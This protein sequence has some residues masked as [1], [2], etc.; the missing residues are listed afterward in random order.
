[1]R[2]VIAATAAVMLSTPVLAG[3]REGDCCTPSGTVNLLEGGLTIEG[4]FH[5]AVL[6]NGRDDTGYSFG[7]AGGSADYGA[8][9][10]MGPSAQAARAVLRD[11]ASRRAAEAANS[12][13]GGTA[14]GP[15]GLRG[16]GV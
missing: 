2:L 6:G 1:M 10:A 5:L 11:E 3:G 16:G 12:I 14:T 13:G 15:G 7:G 4:L 8:R 9:R